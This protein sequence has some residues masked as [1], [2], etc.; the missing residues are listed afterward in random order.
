MP[1]ALLPA[2]GSSALIA[3]DTTDWSIVVRASSTD[4]AAVGADVVR[5][6]PAGRV[7]FADPPEPNLVAEFVRGW[8][9]GGYTIR[10]TQQRRTLHVPHSPGAQDVLESAAATLLARDWVNTPSNVKN[11]AWMVR[12]ARRI[13]ARTGAQVDVLAGRRLVAGGFGGVLAVGA[14]SASPPRV[15]VL[16]RPGSG[17]RVTLIGKG[18]TFDSGGLSIK[19]RESMMLMKTDMAGAAAALAAITLAPESLDLTL[20]LGFAE[21]AVSGSSYRPGDV[22]RHVD[23]QTSEVLNTDAEGRLVLADLLGYARTV[24]RPDLVVD[25]ATLTGAATLALSRHYGALYATDESLAQSLVAAGDSVGELLWRMPLVAEYE[26]CLSSQIADRAHVPTDTTVGAGSI[27][28]ALFL[29]AFAGDLRWAHLDI[30]GPARAPATAGVAV[31]GGT[32]FGAALLG[33]WLQGL[34]D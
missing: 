30:A 8:L 18:I 7:I 23:G 19:P 32:G 4:W 13:A 9:L 21:N 1:R 17:R 34:A 14:G 33:R 22:V 28:A 2:E 20:L 31:A 29:K 6:V 26:A 5:R 27:T 12:Q 3:G 24:V 15:V 11:P 16:R 10:T 25:V